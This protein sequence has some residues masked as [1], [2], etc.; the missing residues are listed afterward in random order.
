[1][2]A[3]DMRTGERRFVAVGRLNSY[4]AA[5]WSPDGTRIAVEGPVGRGD[6]GRRLSVLDARTGAPEW[7]HDIPLTRGLAGRGAW[8]PDGQRLAL[9]AFDGCTYDCDQAGYDARRH[10]VEQVDPTTGEVVGAPLPLAGEPFRA[11]G[12]RGGRDLVFTYAP[13]GTGHPHVTL[14][15]LRPDGTIDTLVETPVGVSNVDLPDDLVRA[16]A[17][18]GRAPQPSIWAAPA[19]AYLIAAVPLL[20]VLWL[21]RRVRRRRQAA[22]V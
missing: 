21:V 7:T 6:T 2:V 8:S 3:I 15:A 14:V 18:G 20:C 16:G 10:R 5:A 13:D 9:F 17:F 4:T 19:W 12:W 11:I 1:M 22:R